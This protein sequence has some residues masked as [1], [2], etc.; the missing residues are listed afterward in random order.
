MLEK[1]NLHDE[2]IISCLRASYGIPVAGIAFL[3]IGNGAAAWAYRVHTADGTTYFLKIRKGRLN[4]S[5][6]V[7]PRYLHDH[8]VAQI[9]APLP[10]TTQAEWTG[11]GNFKLILYPFIAGHTGMDVGMADHHWIA[12]GAV[13]RQI[14]ATVLP[15]DLAQRMKHETFTPTWSGT[16]KHLEAHITTRAFAD[17]IQ[18]ELAAFWRARRAE[19]RTLVDLAEALGQRLQATAT[20]LVLCHAGGEYQIRPYRPCRYPYGKCPTRYGKQSVDRGLG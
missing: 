13:L 11:L 15:P 20:P 17:P 5:S 16:V 6:L 14:H 7:V 9:V 1:P 4:E 10:T 19:I 18:H 2:T 3:P 12:Y 8:G